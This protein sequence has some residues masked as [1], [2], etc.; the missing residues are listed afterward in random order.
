MKQQWWHDWEDR[1]F[2]KFMDFYCERIYP[3]VMALA[4]LALIYVG[5]LAYGTRQ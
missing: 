1:P 5:F 2:A 4:F 3:A